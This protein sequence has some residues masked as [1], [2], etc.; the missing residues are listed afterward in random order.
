MLHSTLLVG[1][2]PAMGIAARK[3]EKRSGYPPVVRAGARRKMRA[4]MIV[5]SVVFVLALA[6]CQQGPGTTN[7]GQETTPDYA[8]RVFTVRASDFTVVD[9]PGGIASVAATEYSMS[10]ITKDVI[11]NGFVQA[12]IESPDFRGTWAA[13]PLTLS[14]DVSGLSLTVSMSYGFY[15]G[16]AGLTVTGNLTATEMRA[17]LPTFNGYRFRVVVSE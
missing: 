17:V 8:S 1:I 12:H 9:I 2:A 11:D 15:L 3:R 16:K 5:A 14:F 10:E 7:S 13:L 4:T 6:A